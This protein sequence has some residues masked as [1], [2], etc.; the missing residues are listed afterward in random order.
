MWLDDPYI[1]LEFLECHCVCVCV[2]MLAHIL[3]LLEH[4]LMVLRSTFLRLSDLMMLKNKKDKCSQTVN[5]VCISEILLLC[6]D[7]WEVQC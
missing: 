4:K 5:I 6:M 2:C 3:Y 1:S 7:P